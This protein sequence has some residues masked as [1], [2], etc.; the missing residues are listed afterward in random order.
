MKVKLQFYLHV[1]FAFSLRKIPV[2]EVEYLTV[3]C[4]NLETQTLKSEGLLLCATFFTNTSRSVVGIKTLR[5]STF[6]LKEV[7]LSIE[8]WWHY[9]WKWFCFYSEKK[10]KSFIRTASVV[11]TQC[12]SPCLVFITCFGI[13]NVCLQPKVVID[14]FISPGI[15]FRHG[16]IMYELLCTSQPHTGE[17]RRQ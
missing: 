7:V 15:I 10:K 9:V 12:K 1:C 4:P 8:K 6:M 3:K 2:A 17:E 13:N 5:S 14:T 11:A 16:F